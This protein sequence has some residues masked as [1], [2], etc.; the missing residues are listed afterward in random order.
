LRVKRFSLNTVAPLFIRH[1]AHKFALRFFALALSA[2]VKA[3][4]SHRRI[5][6][7][8]RLGAL[9][10][11]F[12]ARPRRKVAVALPSHRTFRWRWFDHRQPRT[13]IDPLRPPLD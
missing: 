6:L 8:P 3:M 7:T 4:T 12:S 10:A 9:G 11:T 2:R 5:A 13:S 1:E